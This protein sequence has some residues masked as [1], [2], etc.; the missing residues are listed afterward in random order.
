MIY[1]FV[2]TLLGFSLFFMMSMQT[3]FAGD[4]TARTE[5]DWQAT[6][7]TAVNVRSDC[8]TGDVVGVVPGGEVVRILEVDRFNE[9]YLIESSAGTGFV[10]ASFLKDIVESPLSNSVFVDLD[11]S[12]P[13]YDAILDVKE[14]GIV[15]GTPDGRILADEPINRVELAKILVEATSDDASISQAVLGADVYSDVELD[16]WY[17][18]YLKIAHERNIMRG[19]DTHTGRPSVRPADHANGAEVA[20]MIAVAF[21]LEIRTPVEGEAWYAPYLE[22]LNALGALPYQSPEHLVTR[23]EMMFMVS[24]VLQ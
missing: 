1:R 20:K 24:T 22:S 13:Y 3:V 21:G 7:T 10:Y 16:A 18:P 15:N 9:F 23:G 12:H 4:C 5:V 6:I 17:S 8:P 14:R 2:A 19:D 11:A